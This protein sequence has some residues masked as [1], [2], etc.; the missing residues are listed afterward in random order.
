MSAI[1]NPTANVQPAASS[2]VA[3]SSQLNAIN[4]KTF[5][6]LLTAQ[7]QHQDPTHPVSEE[8]LAAEMAAFSTATGIDTLNTTA[9]QIASGQQSGSLGTASGLIGKQVATA[10]N[11]LVTDSS[12]KAQGAFTIPAATTDATVSV[13]DSSGAT[14]GT[15]NLGALGAGVHTFSWSGGSPNQAYTFAVTAKDSQGQALTAT[16]SSLYTV[17]GVTLANGAIQLELANNSVPL[18]LSKVQQVL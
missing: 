3:G 15:L 7:L 12:G 8:Q 9:S 16:T 17:N 4:E 18:A 6:Q 10:G 13:Q 2:Q 11:A 5:M 1:S 14:V